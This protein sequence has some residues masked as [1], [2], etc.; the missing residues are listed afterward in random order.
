MANKSPLSAAKNIVE[1][2]SKS[3]NSIGV[4]FRIFHRVK[5]S[6]SIDKKL[7]TSEKYYKKESKIQDV[8]GIR[9]VL[10]F[11]DDI[12]IVHGVISRIYEESKKDTS[13]D[14]LDATTFK[15]VRYNIV[16]KLSENDSYSVSDDVSEYVDSTFELQIRT[17]LSEGWHEVEHDMRYKFK[18][19]WADSPAEYRR[20]NGVY[21][22]IET[23]E[24]TMIKILED[25]AYHHYKEKNW[26]SMLRQKFRLRIYDFTIGDEITNMFNND[27]GLAKSFFRLDRDAL[28][29]RLYAL[30]YDYPLK[31][32]N[33]ILFANVVFIKDKRILD[34]TPPVFIEEF[35]GRCLAL[36]PKSAIKP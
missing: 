27:I 22:A 34:L 14:D 13:I 1:T 28:I 24:W 26:E 32:K 18:S 8:I 2:I 25:V 35:N 31:L 4:M 7:Q 11:S 6:T 20:L 12:K 19:D 10:Y 36:F 9:V 33:L 3:L 21:A 23:N 17:V 16:Y 5:D 29:E 15:P 30:N